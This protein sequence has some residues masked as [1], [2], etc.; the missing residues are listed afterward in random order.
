MKVLVNTPCLKLCGGVANHFMGL[1]NYWGADVKYNTIG[2][3]HL[4]SPIETIFLTPFDILKYIIRII[5][6]RPDIVMVNPSMAP[7]A[8]KRD[9]MYL[10]IA[11]F[12][13]YKTSVMFHGFHEES[14]RDMKP[15][16]V[17]SLN[18]AA[19][20]FVLAESFK[21]TLVE[22]GVTTPIELTTTKVDD[23]LLKDFSIERRKGKVN[24]IIYLA[25]VTK[26]KGIFVSLDIFDLLSK[27]YP[28]LNFTVVGSGEDLEEA[29]EYAKG[30]NIPNITFTGLCTGEELIEQYKQADLYLF[31]SYH[32]GMPTSVLEAMAFGL[33]VVTRPVGGLVDFFDTKMGSMVDS[34]SPEDFIPSIAQMITDSEYTKQ[35]SIYNYNYAKNRFYASQVA[36]GLVKALEKYI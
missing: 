35:I 22:W 13:G 28:Q 25:R 19:V 14:V 16:I 18:N 33:P 26:E 10:K 3:R 12:L 6:F 24:N 21:S 27:Q 31:T 23:N 8:I 7:R 29:K 4:N 11:R 1:K 34:F 2:K 32:E 17:E 20:I 9:C 5:L 36:D 30:K 15:M